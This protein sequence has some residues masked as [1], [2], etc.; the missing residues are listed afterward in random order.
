MATSDRLGLDTS[1]VV[2]LVTGL[3]PHAAA[4]A[5]EF[6]CCRYESG[7]QVIVSDLVVAEAY[8]ALHTH[9]SIPKRD[10]IDTLLEF[11]QN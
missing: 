8:F 4:R 10:A 6:L 2:R 7:Q 5:Q 11:L 9:Y 1:V 3:P